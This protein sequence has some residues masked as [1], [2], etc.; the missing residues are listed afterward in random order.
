MLVGRESNIRNVLVKE[1]GRK[2]DNDNGE[3]ITQTEVI[4]F[5]LW[6]SIGRNTSLMDMPDINCSPALHRHD[7]YEMPR[8]G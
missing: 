6:E 1:Y 3:C 2:K 7:N 5:Y 8:L 4:Q